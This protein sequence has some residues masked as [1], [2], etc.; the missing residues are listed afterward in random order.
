MADAMRCVI[1]GDGIYRKMLDISQSRYGGAK[2]GADVSNPGAAGSSVIRR[3][4]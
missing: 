4:L 2:L 1:K 3:S